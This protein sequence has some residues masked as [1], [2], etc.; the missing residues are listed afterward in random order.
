MD[1]L[2]V[3]QQ[4]RVNNFLHINSSPSEP[5]IG[6]LMC[7]NGA[8]SFYRWVKSTLGRAYSSYDELNA[9]ASQSPVGSRG[10]IGIPYGNGAERTLGNKSLGASLAGIDLNIHTV[11]DLIRASQEGV[12]FALCYGLEIMSDMGLTPRCVRAANANMFQS[13][14]FQR[15]FATATGVPLELYTTD[16]AT[17]A[18]RGA[19]IGAG[20][21]SFSDAFRGL[22]RDS[23]IEPDQNALL[24]T[25]D[26]YQR[27]KGVV[28]QA[29]RCESAHQ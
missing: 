28:T 21:F 18:A 12:V 7:V 19:G 27:W 4:S 24:A 15:T 22:C 2:G 16:G 10:L 11:S 17:G 8:G 3:D 20:L 9:L 13:D 25:R 1:R 6:V 14:L 23:T 26:A 29:L 5:R